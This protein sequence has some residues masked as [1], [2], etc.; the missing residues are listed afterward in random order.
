MECE[1]N[2]SKWNGRAIEV[3]GDTWRVE[4]KEW[5]RSRKEVMRGW[6]ETRHPKTRDATMQ[7]PRRVFSLVANRTKP[8]TY[9]V[10]VVSLG[11]SKA[12]AQARDVGC[13]LR[14]LV[15]CRILSSDSTITGSGKGVN[16]QLKPQVGCLGCSRNRSHNLGMDEVT[17]VV[18]QK[19]SL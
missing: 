4:V 10:V 13:R 9:L 7:Q 11:L 2:N 16:A 17:F 18:M 14:S 19:C 6:T 1:M 5:R 3:S 8:W 12:A 15:R